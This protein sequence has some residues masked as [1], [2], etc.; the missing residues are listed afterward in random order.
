MACNRYS[1]IDFDI[2]TMAFITLHTLQYMHLNDKNRL[3]LIV[4]ICYEWISAKK[5]SCDQNDLFKLQ[6]NLYEK[7]RN[8]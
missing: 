4:S 1:F 7:K 5:D 3:H 2:G 6:N 8:N